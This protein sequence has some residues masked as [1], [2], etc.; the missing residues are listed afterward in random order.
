[1]ELIDIES[2]FD[3]GHI[4]LKMNSLVDPEIIAA[5]C[6]ASQRGTKVVLI[7]RGIC[8]LL[9]GVPGV[10]DNITVISVVGRYLEHSRVFRFGSSNRGMRYLIG[11]ADMMQ[12]NLDGRVEA[13]VPIT[14]A[15]DIARLDRI[16]ELYLRNDIKRWEL[17]RNGTWH[18]MTSPESIDV[19]EALQVGLGTDSS[20]RRETKPVVDVI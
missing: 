10:S 9:P 2:Y 12:R 13:L 20:S 3:D 7:I 1:L 17:D 4:V 5:L 11:S 16:F 19:H 6:S 8:C 18:N 14:A 15:Y